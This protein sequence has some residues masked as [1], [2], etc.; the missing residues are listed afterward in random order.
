MGEPRSDIA[1]PRTVHT[2]SERNYE[3]IM[4]STQ[5]FLQIGGD[6]AFVLDH[7]HSFT[8]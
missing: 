4:K 8:T 7:L 2:H 6:I 3:A 5:V 1:I